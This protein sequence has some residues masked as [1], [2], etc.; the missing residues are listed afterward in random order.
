MYGTS[1]LCVL[2]VRF[3]R[4]RAGEGMVN[5]ATRAG[6]RRGATE[7][8]VW[9]DGNQRR[10]SPRGK[11]KKKKTGRRAQKRKRSLRAQSRRAA[12]SPAGPGRAASA[13]SATS[14]EASRSTS[15]TFSPSSPLP[16]TSF[17]SSVVFSTISTALRGLTMTSRRRCGGEGF[18]TALHFH[19]FAH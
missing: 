1:S 10:M 18:S 13:S 16:S 11:K 5:A 17:G 15:T 2:W 12:L 19:A 7:G 8:V 3:C 9:G 6:G 4:E 14:D